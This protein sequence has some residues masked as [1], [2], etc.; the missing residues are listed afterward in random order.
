MRIAILGAG[1]VG[2]TLGKRFAGTGHE[3]F[4]G[5]PNPAEY[6]DQN[7]VGKVGTV[8]EAAQ[9]AK[10]IVLA[11]P[12]AAIEDAI[13]ECGD[14]SGKIV[15][16]CTNPLTKTADGLSLSLGFETSAAEK[17]AEFA[18]HAKVVKCFNQ[19]GFNNME[20]PE[21][22]GVKSMMFV[23]GDDAQ[24][25]DTVRKLAESIGFDAVNAGG[26]KTARLLEPLAML[27]IHLSMTSNLKR[28]FAFAI[29]R[30]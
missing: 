9:E 30:R 7:L 16:D 25:S 13:K 26:L 15:V 14:I 6:A 18:A 20:N 10:M 8:A 17:V 12:F 19:T 22:N 27:W 4:F 1:M 2:G 21:V 29:L 24:S 5:V 11:V 3:V 23:C 28:D